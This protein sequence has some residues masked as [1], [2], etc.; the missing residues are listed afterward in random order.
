MSARPALLLLAALALPAAWFVQSPPKTAPAVKQPAAPAWHSFVSAD[1]L[2]A[3]MR[4]EP[5]LIVIDARSPTEYAA[6]HIPGAIN[7][8]GTSM[9]TVKTATDPRGGQNVFRAADGSPDVGRY[10]KLLGDAGLTRGAAVVVY[11][12][13]GGKADGSVAAML[14]DWLGQ[15]DVA[16][17]DGI[18][19]SE[20]LG[21]GRT[22]T[23]IPT[24]RPKAVYLADPRPDTVWTLRNVLA[25]LRRPDVIFYDTRTPGEFAGEPDARGNK[26]GGHIPGAVELC[27]S[28]FLT[29]RKTL[30]SRDQIKAALGKRGITPDK[31]VVLYCQT[32][33]RVSL[34]YL[35]LK[36]LGY[37]KIAFYD[38][39]WQ[40]YGNRDDTPKQTQADRPVPAA[41]AK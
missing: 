5:N 29:P 33:T 41:G 28:D 31:T 19:P 22:L 8:P 37:R 17:L 27:Y 25:D 38:A 36:D 1:Q 15:R 12:N 24:V 14:L 21:A 4:A 6:G 13:H 10:E 9:R 16:F 34:P 35:V 2:A 26:F 32:G 20:W 23:T 11:G 40:E 39:S 7:L 3:R 30:V 18:G